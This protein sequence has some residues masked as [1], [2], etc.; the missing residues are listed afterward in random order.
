MNK[1]RIDVNLKNKVMPS[2]GTKKLNE[3]YFNNDEYKFLKKCI[4][5]KSVFTYGKEVLEF[6]NLCSKF[7]Q[8]KSSIALSSGLRHYIWLYML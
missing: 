4:V 7:L 1:K 5:N 6:E 8:T 3:P 2:Q